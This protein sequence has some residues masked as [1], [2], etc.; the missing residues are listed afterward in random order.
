MGLNLSTFKWVEKTPSAKPT[1]RRGH[2]AVLYNSKMYIFGGFITEGAT[3]E[4][5]AL[6]LNQTVYEWSE[7]VR[8]IP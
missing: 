5:W 1:A 6:Q 2:S 7:I 3:N 8:I 4:L